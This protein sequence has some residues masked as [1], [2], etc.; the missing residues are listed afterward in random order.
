MINNNKIIYE[1]IFANDLNSS[2][3][4]ILT[5]IY[6]QEN[7]LKLAKKACKTGL[8]FNPYS[9]DAELLLANINIKL[10]NDEKAID[11]LKKLLDK[12]PNH[13]RAIKLY[14]YLLSKNNYDLKLIEPSIK[15]LL[16]L[17]PD[18]L[19]ALDWIKNNNLKLSKQLL[20]KKENRKKDYLKEKN[21]KEEK[22]NIIEINPLMA[23]LSMAKILVSQK[24]YHEAL[25]VLKILKSKGKNLKTVNNEIKKTQ[26]LLEKKNDS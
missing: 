14:I 2:I 16:K 20:E 9:F 10:N 11:I 23:T 15:H 7:N 5:E 17:F 13:F 1:K 3:Y 22:K 12:Q 24:H 4:L 26:K 6:L 25:E 8:T 21:K 18:D 19:F